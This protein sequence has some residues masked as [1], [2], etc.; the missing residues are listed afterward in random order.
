MVT[1]IR[2]GLRR[3]AGLG[4][5]ILAATL[6]AGVASGW[7]DSGGSLSS[8][9]SAGSLWSPTYNTLGQTSSTHLTTITPRGSIEPSGPIGTGSRELAPPTHGLDSNPLLE[10]HLDCFSTPVAPGRD[11]RNSFLSRCPGNSR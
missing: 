3:S 11:S 7:A 1:T 10:R 6:L 8:T 4:A 2:C 5:A 9:G